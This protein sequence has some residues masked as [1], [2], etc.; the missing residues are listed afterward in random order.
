MKNQVLYVIAVVSYLLMVAALVAVYMM[1]DDDASRMIGMNVVST[2]LMT[3]TLILA[4]LFVKNKD[5][6]RM[7]EEFEE[8]QRRDK[9]NR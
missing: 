9:E 2:A 4:V 7:Y 6:A 5:K 3:I 8:L 1:T